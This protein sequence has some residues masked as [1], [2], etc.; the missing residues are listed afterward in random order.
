MDNECFCFCGL[1]QLFS[2]FQAGTLARGPTGHT[3]YVSHVFLHL[4]SLMQ[5]CHRWM[6]WED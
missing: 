4:P 2:P 5:A 6:T 3:I 1:L